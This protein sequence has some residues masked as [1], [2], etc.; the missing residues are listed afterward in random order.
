MNKTLKKILAVLFVTVLI[1]AL[2]SDIISANPQIKF[3]LNDYLTAESRKIDFNE[4]YPDVSEI[5]LSELLQR[6]N[7]DYNRSLMLINKENHLTEDFSSDIAEYKDTGV[8]MN[9]SIMSAYESLANDIF[10]KFGEKL[11][12]SSAY[13]TDDEQE[14]LEKENK[15]ATEAGASEHCA[16]LAL[17]VYVKY[18]AGKAFIKSESG[19]FV[20]E[21]CYE[22][23]FIIRYPFYGEKITGIEFEPWHLRY[24]G[25][26]HAEIIY[27]N[28]LTF[29]EYIS[30]LE[31]GKFY[32]YGDYTVT[33]Q[34]GDT[35]KIPAEYEAVTVSP[36]NQ[37]GYIY[38]FKNVKY[39]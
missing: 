21:N 27:K 30:S 12:V 22:Y 37:N 20:N 18:R 19:I 34:K 1:S 32:K 4:A 23:G 17:D 9:V 10:E 26:P 35:P 11:F 13:R 39:I 16:G 2:V 28:R 3:Y 15:Y 8:K 25:L 36:D 38:T 5:Q 7:T 29:E 33:R 14:V 31:Y 24:V 6:E